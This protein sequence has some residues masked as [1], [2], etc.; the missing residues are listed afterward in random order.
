MIGQEVPSN[1]RIII[2]VLHDACYE[3]Y[4]PLVERLIALGVDINMSIKDGDFYDYNFYGSA[5]HAAT[6]AGQKEIARLLISVGADVR[7]KK[8]QYK[9]K[10]VK[11]IT[12]VAAALL[13]KRSE[14]KKVHETCELLIEA[15][16]DEEDGNALLE[17]CVREDD[18]E[19][20]RR[21]LDFGV[22]LPQL[23]FEEISQYDTHVP[24]I[25]IEVVRLL[26]EH[27]A[28]TTDPAALQ[29]QAASR[30]DVS[31]LQYLVKVY[32][33]HIA[34]TDVGVIAYDI[35]H[36]KI[37][38]SLDMLRYLICD[39]KFDVNIIFGGVSEHGKPNSEGTNFLRIACRELNLH[40]V[41]L[42]LELGVDVNCPGLEE[43]ALDL[44]RKMTPSQRDGYIFI[45]PIIRLLVL[46][47]IQAFDILSVVASN[48]NRTTTNPDENTLE[49]VRTSVAGYLPSNTPAE[50]ESKP[51]GTKSSSRNHEPDHLPHRHPPPNLIPLDSSMY[52]PLFGWKPLRLLRI[53]PSATSDGALETTFVNTTLADSEDFEVLSF[54][55]S[56]VEASAHICING[57]RCSVAPELSLLLRRFRDR[58]KPRILWIDVLCINYYDIEEKTCQVSILKDIYA[59]AT[60]ILVYLG[61]EADDS[62]LLYE[63]IADW[64]PWVEKVKT[65]KASATI[66]ETDA[67][68]RW[69]DAQ[70][71][72]HLK[73][74]YSKILQRPWF[75]HP[76]TL[77]QLLS[78]KN[79]VAICGDDEQDL[80][81]L[82]DVARERGTRKI[83]PAH[84]CAWTP[85]RAVQNHLDSMHSIV[86]R[87]EFRFIDALRSS[88][89]VEAH[90]PRDTIFS[91]AS[92]FERPLINVDYRLSVQ[93]VYYKLTESIIEREANLK[94]VN[95]AFG[96]R[97]TE[98]KY[99][100]GLPSWVPDYRALAQFNDGDTLRL[101][102]WSPPYRI[103][104][105]TRFEGNEM[106]TRGL[107]LDKI[108]VLTHLP[109]PGICLYNEVFTEVLYEWE[110]L[111][112]SLK[113]K[114][115]SLT[116]PDAFLALLS[117]ISRSNDTI[118]RYAPEFSTWYRLHGTGPL[119]SAFPSYFAE[120]EAIRKWVGPLK[121]GQR[122]YGPD[123]EENAE[124][125]FSQGIKRMCS[126]E[127]LFTTE[128]GTLGMARGKDVKN[129]DEIVWLAGGS[130]AFIMR[131]TEGRWRLVGDCSLYGLDIVPLWE[132]RK[133]ELVEFRIV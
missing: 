74:A 91:V 50:V 27:G 107:R 41:R 109:S 46:G 51:M 110:T 11:E 60:R 105:D 77:L 103:D 45:L 28:T 93:D 94:I 18:A 133:R 95:I 59:A 31:L 104:P 121:P 64:I 78:C 57:Q 70:L 54:I 84:P 12:P 131:E 15:G 100:A 124:R 115:F 25:S 87:P 89:N 66:F 65:G 132:K 42:L 20:V 125:A 49:E 52:L 32:G 38:D 53:E 117:R 122:P 13:W 85:P 58:H 114:S 2:K 61:A 97:R 126:G 75:F 43:T 34:Q 37:A 19:I 88:E 40:A 24:N 99:T 48:A 3:A 123:N 67:N 14:P 111:A 118:E 106:V 47:T 26:V 86:D 62:H 116:I 76:W 129:G 108:K 7:A 81:M 96:E 83:Q 4:V 21:L 69:E 39:Y 63:R 55:P 80:F 68:P 8:M 22:Q 127:R 71:K 9:I 10:K 30:G 90:D 112:A 130:Q 101:D 82:C 98:R 56:E 102:T 119:L 6:T 73:N 35:I 128:N 17:H 23:S 72:E 5:L 120:L 44:V 16:A 29:K 36:S 33:K 1:D 79:A 113:N 92:L